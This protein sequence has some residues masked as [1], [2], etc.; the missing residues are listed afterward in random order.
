VTREVPG[1][2]LFGAHNL[3]GGIDCAEVAPELLR[4]LRVVRAAA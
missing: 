1:G 2:T 3:F 4:D